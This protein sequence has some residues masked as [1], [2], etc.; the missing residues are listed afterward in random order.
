MLPSVSLGS[1]PAPLVTCLDRDQPMDVCASPLSLSHPVTSVTSPTSVQPSNISGESLSDGG[2]AATAWRTK[3]RTTGVVGR[4][5]TTMLYKLL[6][7][8]QQESAG[9]TPDCGGPLMPSSSSS[10]DRDLLRTELL[11]TSGDES[12]LPH[13]NVD[14]GK[15]LNICTFDIE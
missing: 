3:D 12:S 9:G 13:L 7:E 8:E 5:P 14:D 11:S 4:V 1:V 10:S 15:Q 2:G 6:T